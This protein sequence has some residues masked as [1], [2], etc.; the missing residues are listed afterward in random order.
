MDGVFHS[1]SGGR[2]DEHYRYEILYSARV[3][4]VPSVGDSV[5]FVPGVGRDL[6]GNSPHLYNPWVRIVGEQKV[7]VE[8]TTLTTLTPSN[9]S[10]PAS[11]SVSPLR[12]DLDKNIEDVALEVGLPGHL[13][14]YNM[15]E[16][17]LNLNA[18][19][20]TSLGLLTADSVKLLYEVYYFTNLGQYVNSAQGTITCSDSLF[21][22]DCLQNPGNVFL[23][24][25]ARSTE[26]RLV[27]SG[28]YIAQLNI[29][30]KAG[31]TIVSKTET[32]SVWGVRRTGL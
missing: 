8:S 10:D 30:M 19:R 22:G 16:L 29:R 15:A 28:A 13:I 14:E 4:E 1:I 3:G 24:W 21:G 20:D 17:L 7:I 9:T 11:P 27:G 32:D 26:G 5:R 18:D 2:Y 31:D 23:A 6:S 25:N 12:V